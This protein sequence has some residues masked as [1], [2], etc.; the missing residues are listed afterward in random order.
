M[1]SWTLDRACVVD[2]APVPVGREGGSACEC[3]DGRWVVW[4]GG[5]DGHWQN[6][7]WLFDLST[8]SWAP[9]PLQEGE[10]PLERSGHTATLTHDETKMVVFGGFNGEDKVNSVL[11]DVAV[12]DLDDMHSL[13]WSF[14]EWYVV[15]LWRFWR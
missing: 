13:R 11:G 12:L 9:A 8:F 5:Y 1:T 3:K 14:P 7:T 4:F 15:K 6:D 2:N 10:K